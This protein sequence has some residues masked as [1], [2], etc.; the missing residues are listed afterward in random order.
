MTVNSGTGNVTFNEEFYSLGQMTK[1]IQPNAVRINSTANASFNTVAF[2]NPDGSRALVALN[3]NSTTS[4]IRVYVDGE[5]FTYAIPG[6]SVATF[7]WDA[8]GADF[9]NGSFDDGAYHL[10]GGSL[11]AWVSFGNTASNVVASSQ[12]VLEGEKA[13]KLFG[14]FNAQ[15]NTSGVYQGISVTPGE[16]VQSSLSALTRAADSIVGTANQAQMKIEFYSDYGALYGSGAYLGELVETI[17]DGQSL[18]D[19]WQLSHLGGI[20]PASAVE[21]RLVLQFIQPN[22]Q[23]GSVFVDEVTFGVASPPIPGDFNNDGHVNGND[24]AIWSEAYGSTAQGDADIDGDTDG[25]DFLIWQRN[26]T[27]NQL[28]EVLISVPEPAA[29]S[30]CW[31][32]SAI[33]HFC[34]RFRS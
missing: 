19:V 4:T 31:L 28:G 25:A 13:L 15:P 24:L 7:L 8:D 20:A 30:L 18:N 3:P 1:A 21:A 27:Q 5:H 23:N 14:Q 34:A 17:S 33:F 10:G 2:Q 11:D 29:Q 9:D 22:G 6:K 32:A 12:A 16:Y 26:I